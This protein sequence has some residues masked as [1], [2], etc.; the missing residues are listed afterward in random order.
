MNIEFSGNPRP[1]GIIGLVIG[2]VAL[3]ISFIPCIGFYALIPAILALIFCVIAFLFLKQNNENTAVPFSGIIIGI[4]AIGMSVYQYY[5][6]KEVYDTKS[7]IEKSI[8]E[9]TEEVV[10][11]LLKREMEEIKKHTDSTGKVSNDT[12]DHVDSIR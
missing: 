1:F 6:Y 11:D 4:V 3:L 9:S 10:K 12:I 5:H 2:I 8:N 7:E